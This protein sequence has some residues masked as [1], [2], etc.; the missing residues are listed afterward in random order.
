VQLV[1]LSDIFVTMAPTG[2]ANPKNPRD[3]AKRKNGTYYIE[4]LTDR[5]I[6]NKRRVAAGLAPKHINRSKDTIKVCEKKLPVA[7]ASL[8]FQ[9]G[10]IDA[11]WGK[12]VQ[13]AQ[14]QEIE[15]PNINEAKLPKEYQNSSARVQISGNSVAVLKKNIAGLMAQ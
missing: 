8:T 12:V 4:N 6:V 3:A 9:R 2:A 15:L 14:S 11:E 13:L 5:I 10:K 7:Y 1:L